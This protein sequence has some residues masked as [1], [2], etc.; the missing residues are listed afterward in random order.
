MRRAALGAA[1]APRRRRFQGFAG[2]DGRFRE[3]LRLGRRRDDKKGCG[4]LIRSAS[5]SQNATGTAGASMRIEGD[6]TLRSVHLPES[7]VVEI[8]NRLD[9]KEPAGSAVSKRGDK[10]RR[11]PR[12]RY[13][14]LD[15]LMTVHQMG[16]GMHRFLVPTRDI[17]A[18][19]VSILH[20][21][22]LHTGTDVKMH[23]PTV[24]GQ[25]TLVEGAVLSCEHVVGAVHLIVVMFY[26]QIDPRTFVA[27][28]EGS[29]PLNAEPLQ[30]PA[31]RGKALMIDDQPFEARL[32]KHYLRETSVELTH[33]ASM[34]QA[35]AALKAQPVDIILCDLNL[36]G[37]QG[38]AVIES[39]RQAGYKGPI[40]ALT[41]EWSRGR[42]A[43]ARA[44]GAAIVMPKPY[45]PAKLLDN[46][47]EFL[48][49]SEPAD[50]TPLFSK[51]EQDEMTRELV[52]QFIDDAHTL[53][54]ELGKA[55]EEGDVHGARQAA[56]TLKEAGGGYGFTELFEAAKQAITALDASFSIEESIQDLRRLQSMCGRLRL[57]GAA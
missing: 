14:H 32:I 20:G 19:G 17:S 37:E 31:M 47:A 38:E 54:D 55:I 42:L 24:S 36:G 33:A 25:T 8:L 30:A 34:E 2:E 4:G 48:N 45:D 3:S 18:N 41:G 49:A 7:R 23:L 11:Q 46:M 9:E 1:I 27:S 39:L 53:S 28:A 13:R 43:E 6:E 22:Y 15:V 50:E 5:A 44:A 40:I 52:R 16:G 29:D 51:L 35:L 21:G 26:H 56:I 57:R 10:R 12:H